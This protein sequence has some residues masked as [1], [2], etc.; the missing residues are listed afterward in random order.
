M[1]NGSF[2]FLPTTREEMALRSWD[3]LD[4]LLVT[5]DAYIDHPSF[6]VPLIG[7]VLESRG[8]KVGIIAQPDW[9]NEEDITRMGRPKLFVGISAGSMDSMINKYTAN[10]RPR[11]YDA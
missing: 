7:R 6:G 10:K 3:Q 4:I 5:G 11:D 2:D 8:F 1:K 9:R